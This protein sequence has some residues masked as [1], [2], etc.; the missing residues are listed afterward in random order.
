MTNLPPES[1]H[2]AFRDCFRAGDLEGILA[3][4]EDDAT[5]VQADGSSRQGKAAVREMMSGLLALGGEL[6]LDTR[7][8]VRRGDLALLSNRW[9]LRGRDGDGQP[10]ELSGQTTEVVRRQADGRWLYLIDHPW[11]G[12]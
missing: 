2:T 11:G 6:E 10:F 1:A 9:T 12:A 5:I 8:A 4:Y 3:L 7:Y